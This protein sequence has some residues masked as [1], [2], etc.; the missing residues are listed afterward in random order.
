MTRIERHKDSPDHTHTLRESDRLKRPEVI[1][2]L[3]KEEAIKSYPPVAIVNAIKEHAT[4]HL[5]LGACVEDLTR[6]EVTNIKYKVRGSMELDLIGDPKL[7]SDI[8]QA[9]SYLQNQEYYVEQYYVPS[10][11]TEGIVFIHPTQLEKLQ[12]HGWL[13][14]IDSTHKTNKHGWRLF[15][16]YIRDGYGCWNIGAHFFVSKEDSDTIAEALKIIRTKCHRWTPRYAL[17]D[18]S[19]AEANSIK[20]AFPGLR[21]GKQECEVIL[22]VVHVMRTWMSKIYDKK[23]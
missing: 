23:T 12:R 18:Q 14:L 5:N 22:C 3:V 21:A 2:S 7:G 10:R 4:D 11:S 15:T 8:S 9:V 1:R 20:Q 6:K 16:L 13:T 17:L 19:S